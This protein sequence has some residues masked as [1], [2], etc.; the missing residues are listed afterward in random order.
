MGVMLTIDGIQVEIAEGTTILRAAEAVGIYIPQLCAH[1]DLRPEGICGLCMVEIEGAEQ[2]S[3][4]CT[5]L[6]VNGMQVLTNSEPVV[7]ERQSQL[8]KILVHH[9]HACLTCAQSEGCSRTECSSNVSVEA[10]CCSKF[11]NCEIQRVAEFIGIKPDTPRYFYAGLPKVVD[12]PVFNMDYNLCIGCTRCLRVCRDVRGVDALHEVLLD[13][14]GVIV[15]SKADTLAN[16]GC[17][18]CGACVEVCPTGALMDKKA[19]KTKRKISL[20][21]VPQPPRKVPGYEFCADEVVK[22]PEKEGAFE[23]L[24]AEIKVLFIGS[25]ANLREALQEQLDNDEEWVGKVKY[26]VYEED[27]MYS[28]RESELMQRYMQGHGG[29]PEGN[30]FMDVL[31]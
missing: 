13:N 3:K 25:S 14:G 27:P 26:F 4:A 5:T 9:P 16:S 8:A 11:G 17:R 7:V 30:S 22:V 24:D 6:V 20:R 23:L 1:P 12:E 18:F 28:K 2:L 19:R 31:F 29:M 10:R 15:R 21:P